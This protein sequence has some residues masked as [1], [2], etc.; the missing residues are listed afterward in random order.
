MEKE[1][2]EAEI[3]HFKETFA[4]VTKEVGKFIVGQEEIIENVLI[5]I[6]CGGHVLLEGVPGLGKTALV[7]TM[8]TGSCIL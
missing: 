2:L 5:S 4:K 3:A 7:N 6:C 1:E 8:A